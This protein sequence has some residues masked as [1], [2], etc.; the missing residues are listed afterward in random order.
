M[1]APCPLCESEETIVFY[2]KELR[3][4]RSCK[5]CKLIFV[6]KEF[7]LGPKEEHAHYLTHNNDPND[8][9]YRRHLGKLTTPLL[10]KL[11]KASTGLD[12]GSGPGPTLSL[13]MT[14]SGHTCVNYDAYFCPE[15]QRLQTNYDFIAM[16][17]VIEHLSAPAEVITQLKD[18]LRPKGVLAVMTQLYDESID[19]EKWYYKNDPT[20]ITLF[21][22]DSIHYIA[23]R[24]ELELEVI[25][26]DVFF[27]SQN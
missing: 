23:K 19:F 22:I 11:T 25:E 3:Q 21:T 15:E 24:W 20:H 9:G 26:K 5:S 10:R 4:F 17:E 13:I 14:E 27:F 7:Q 8:Q 6:P 2:Q 12:F 1:S 18:L 16:T